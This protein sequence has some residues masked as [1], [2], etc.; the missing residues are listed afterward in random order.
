MEGMDERWV[1]ID[2]DTGL[3]VSWYF[4]LRVLDEVNRSSRYGAPFGLLTL[5]AEPLPGAPRNALHDAMASV[6]AAI[7]GTDLGGFIRTGHVGVLLMHQEP[8][9][10]RLAVERILGRLDDAAGKAG[11]RWSTH[12]L[13]YPD[14]GAEISMLLTTGGN[15]RRESD[16]RPMQLPA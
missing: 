1:L 9:Q 12:L 6:P 7:R 15:D 16:A 2:E 5:E 11:V 4:W 13:C 14:D 8:E 3:H 10:A